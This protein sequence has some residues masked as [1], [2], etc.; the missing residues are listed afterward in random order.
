[1]EKILIS[2]ALIGIGIISSILTWKQYITYTANWKVLIISMIAYTIY[3][4]W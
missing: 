1:M 2:V 3:L 4:S